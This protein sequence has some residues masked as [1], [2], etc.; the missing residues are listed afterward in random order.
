M[1]EK[2][3]CDNSKH[4][5][6]ATTSQ[7]RARAWDKLHNEPTIRFKVWQAK[8]ESRE[9]VCKK[10]QWVERIRIEMP[11]SNH[12]G[13]ARVSWC[14]DIDPLRITTTKSKWPGERL[15]RSY[16]TYVARLKRIRETL[17]WR[18]FV[19]K[20]SVA[21][22]TSVFEPSGHDFELDPKVTELRSRR[23]TSFCGKFP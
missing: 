8:E 14:V 4:K 15:P 1:S 9:A 21:V 19:E 12:K 11:L 23:T 7:C 10:H 13:S 2:A 5:H 3:V 16:P 20:S 17:H 22:G 6:A 18:V